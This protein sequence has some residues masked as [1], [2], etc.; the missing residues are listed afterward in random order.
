MKQEKT[1]TIAG[2]LFVLIS[3]TLLH[4]VYGWTN[5]NV[6]A[7]FFAPVNESVWEHMKLLFFPML[8]YSTGMAIL[9][10]ERRP[11]I[12]SALC[13][14]L[15]AGTFCIPLFYYAY[16]SI[17]GDSILPVDIALFALSTLIAFFIA[18]QLA[19]SCIMS[20]IPYFYVR[21]HARFSCALSC[22]R[23]IRPHALSFL[24]HNAL[25][26]QRGSLSSAIVFSVPAI[27]A[28]A[29]PPDLLCFPPYTRH[30]IIKLQY[31]NETK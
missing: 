9:L 29:E 30:G 20:L 16:T 3:G 6:I 25:T 22:L 8:L 14:G 17:T 12:V 5:H 21:S 7:G 24:R 10:K 26:G 1:F 13:S 18:F 28:L 27:H 15:L 23:I 11:C 2:I 31:Q 4:F 19:Q